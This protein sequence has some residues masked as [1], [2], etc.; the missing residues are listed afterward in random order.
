M[1]YHSSASTSRRRRSQPLIAAASN[2][3]PKA[4]TTAAAPISCPPSAT[5]TCSE[6]T[7]SFNTPAVTMTPQP[8]AKLPKNRAQREAG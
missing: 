8:M 7:M 2:G 5:D 4:M 6:R 1:A 3:E